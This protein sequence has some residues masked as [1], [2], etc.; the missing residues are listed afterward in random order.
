MRAVVDASVAVALFVDQPITKAAEEALVQYQLSA[1]TLVLAEIG[2]AFWKYR[3]AD[4]MSLE[5]IDAAQARLASGMI[6][7]HELLPAV[8][9]AA[10]DLALEHDHPI[11]DCFYLALGRSL[12]AP[13]L[14]VDRK[15]A[16]V[17]AQAGVN[18]APLTAA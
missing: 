13:L 11:Y 6:D 5:K 14:T 4:L 3:G 2:N 17:A 15:L 18:L 1:P 8:A 12:R 16:R 10:L 7:F 9:S